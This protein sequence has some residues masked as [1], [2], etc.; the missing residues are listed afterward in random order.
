MP[1]RDLT[2]GL[3]AAGLLTADEDGTT[4]E[5][6]ATPPDAQRDVPPADVP[7]DGA[8][9]DEDDPAAPTEDDGADR[10]AP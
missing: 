5:S 3:L 6:D 8:S 1:G 10:S 4:T 7:E 9:T 2:L